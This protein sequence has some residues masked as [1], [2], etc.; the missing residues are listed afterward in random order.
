MELSETPLEFLA[1]SSNRLT[2]LLQRG[3]SRAAECFGRWFGLDPDSIN[4]H[5][6]TDHCPH[7]NYNV[8]GIETNV[9]P[10]CG[11]P[12]DKR[13][14]HMAS[15][16]LDHA[17]QLRDAALRDGIVLVLAATGALFLLKLLTGSSATFVQL[18]G[19]ALFALTIIIGSFFVVSP[20]AFARPQRNLLTLIRMRWLF[21]LHLPWIFGLAGFLWMVEIAQ[22]MFG[23]EAMVIVGVFGVFGVLGLVSLA[24][25]IFWAFVN[26]LESSLDLVPSKRMEML[27]FISTAATIVGS[28]GVVVL[29]VWYF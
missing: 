5:S 9:C 25:M 8:Q 19:C 27:E 26:S 4:K 12:F 28:F 3:F 2:A 10:E 6:N 17:L 21:L 13:S 22:D 24:W 7:C 11:K 1:K 23:R 20:A 16:R 18:I 29:F 15:K 14:L